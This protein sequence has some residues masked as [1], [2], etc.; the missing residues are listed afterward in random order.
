[1]TDQLYECP[2]CRANGCG[3]CDDEGEV[4]AE[5]YWEIDLALRENAEEAKA[6]YLAG[7]K[8]DEWMF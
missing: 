3:W 8:E 1:M 2:A 7:L 6:E 5:R 4:T